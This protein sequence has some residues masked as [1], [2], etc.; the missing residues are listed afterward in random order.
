PRRCINFTGGQSRAG[1]HLARPATPS[2]F[3]VR[4]RTRR[5]ARLLRFRPR[6]AEACRTACYASYLA[7]I[8]QPAQAR[9]LLRWDKAVGAAA[10]EMPGLAAHGWRAGAPDP[11][12]HAVTGPAGPQASRKPTSVR[13]CLT[14]LAAAR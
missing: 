7:G 8:V 1:P 5:Y 11:D 4:A 12:M 10:V 3:E 13:R 14:C 6:P 9:T 2:S